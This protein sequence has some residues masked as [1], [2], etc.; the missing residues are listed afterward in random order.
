M[1]PDDERADD[2]V[3]EALRDEI[4]LV[5]DLVVAASTSP[6]HFTQDE[7]DALLGVAD[8]DPAGADEADAMAGGADDADPAGPDVQGPA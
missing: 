7:V 6:R 1:T 3:D 4:E 8:T 5:S 2:L